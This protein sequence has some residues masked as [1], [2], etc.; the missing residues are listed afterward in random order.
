MVKINKKAYLR[1][2]EAMIA[3]VLTFSVIAYISISKDDAN[4]YT[5]KQILLRLSE[6]DEFRSYMLNISDCINKNDNK[7]LNIIIEEETGQNLN[8]IICPSTKKPELPRTNVNAESVY[9]NSKYG[10]EL[11]KIIRMYYWE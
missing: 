2:I 10:S 3:V 6:N 7:T 11:P 4:E 1:T 5:S 9:L 8:Y